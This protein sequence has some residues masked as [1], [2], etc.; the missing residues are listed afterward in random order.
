LDRKV[1]EEHLREVFR[2]YELIPR[3]KPKATESFRA[4]HAKGTM[5]YR[6]PNA[7]S[8]AASTAAGEN[9][10]TKGPL[11]HPCLIFKQSYKLA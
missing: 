1:Q 4:Y 5:S 7:V 2:S 6:A 10:C 3:P 9:G 11:N 8:I